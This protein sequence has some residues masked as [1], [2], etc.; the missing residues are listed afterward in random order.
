M[1]IVCFLESEIHRV[2]ENPVKAGE[3]HFGGAISLN[4]SDAFVPSVDK[5]AD[6]RASPNGDED[7]S[8]TN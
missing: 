5:K 4:L 7:F 8:C 2:S 6:R 3:K 1:K